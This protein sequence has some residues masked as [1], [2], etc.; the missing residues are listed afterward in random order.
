MKTFSAETLGCKLNFSE[1]STLAR[2]LTE[3][4]WQEQPFSAA[5]DLYIINTC[6]VT[7]HA[8]RKCRKLVQQALNHN[9]EASV[10]VTGCFAQLRPEQVARIPG[11]SLVLGNDEKFDL[12]QYL[13]KTEKDHTMVSCGQYKS[14]TR[15]R[16][17]VS[18]GQR[19]RS[20]LKVQDGCDYFC[21]FCTIPLARGRSRSAP[22]E[23]VVASVRDLVADGVREV[24]LTGINLGEYGRDMGTHFYDLLCHILEHTALPRL[25]ISSLEPN[26]LEDRIIKLAANSDGR[27]MPH[28]H[29]PLQSGDDEILEKMRRRYNTA[30]YKDRIETLLAYL[31]EASIGIDVLTGFPGETE[32]HFE[33]T[34]R[35]LS[36]LPF[37]YLHVF[38][39]SERPHTTAIKL[40]NKV[41][42]RI[43]K[44]RTAALKDLSFQKE[45][46]FAQKFVGTVRPVL[47]EKHLNDAGCLEGYTDNYLRVAFEYH[48]GLANSIMEAELSQYSTEKGLF[49]GKIKRVDAPASEPF[50]FNKDFIRT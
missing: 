35:F 16:P 42:G 9:P 34:Y 48:P 32:Q 19:T 41:P 20:F 12:L 50:H 24:V 46:A 3:A 40:K 29:I 5:S 31:P 45:W 36:S 4:G 47:V 39:Y 7:D 17:A 18:T 1:T 10:V 21:S 49:E 37:H 33:R 43:R 26:L 23:E 30:L 27:I 15:F 6:S 22:P 14:L 11:V 44:Q 8:E 25:R 2:H 38:T 28:F 13:A